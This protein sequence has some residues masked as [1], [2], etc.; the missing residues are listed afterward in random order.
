MGVGGGG[1]FYTLCDKCDEAE[2]PSLK[3]RHIHI[4]T[5]AANCTQFPEDGFLVENVSD[6]N[7]LSNFP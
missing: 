3:I 7:I 4:N 1:C 2:V 6:F 5:L